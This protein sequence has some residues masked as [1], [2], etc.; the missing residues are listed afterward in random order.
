MQ[1]TT[2]MA[3]IS[4]CMKRAAQKSNGTK[5]NSVPTIRGARFAPTSL[6]DEGGSKP[7]DTWNCDTY[8]SNR[9]Y[10][11]LRQV[12]KQQEFHTQN[13]ANIRKT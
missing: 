2:P 13:W 12:G 9:F 5:W 1:L 7:T 4:L 6:I 3:D 11:A 8:T 10:E